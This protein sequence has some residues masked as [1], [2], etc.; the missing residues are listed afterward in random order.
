MLRAMAAAFFCALLG[1]ITAASIFH[2][3]FFGL[4]ARFGFLGGLLSLV[5]WPS[6]GTAVPLSPI[7]PERLLLLAMLSALAG[8]WIDLGFIFPT[9]ENST[10]FWIFAGAISGIWGRGSHLQADCSSR[11]RRD[12]SVVWV[13]S[14]GSGILI[15]GTHARV[16]LPSLLRGQVGLSGLFGE[17]STFLLLSALALMS[18]WITCRLFFSQES[19]HTDKQLELSCRRIIAAGLFYLAGVLWLAKIMAWLPP[20]PQQPLL[21]DMWALHFPLIIIAGVVWTAWST[22]QQAPNLSL[23][24]SSMAVTLVLVAVGLIWQGPLRDL[25]SSISAGSI[26]SLPTARLWL[27]RSI[28]LRP[29]QTR[30][31]SLLGRLL[32]S[33]G[34]R[35]E[36]NP[37]NRQDLLQSAETVLRQGLTVSHFNLLS[38][39]LGHLYLWQ[40]FQ[41]DDP[42][43]R[44]RLALDA[45]EALQSAVNFAPQNEPAWIDGSLVERLLLNNP[46]A[47]DQ[48]LHSANAVTLS[49]PPDANVVEEKWG[50]HYAALAVSAGAEELQHAYADRALMYLRMHLKQNN[51]AIQKTGITK[52]NKKERLQILLER[53]KSLAYASEMH[54]ILGEADETAA[55]KNEGE[56]ISGQLN[57]ER[58]QESE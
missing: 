55:L 41:T 21:V 13:T 12:N 7:S 28:S 2:P 20:S 39:K 57:S 1:G 40:A 43:E 11:G 58:M 30:N 6:N 31:Y 38:A 8:H 22:S 29:G 4:G 14:I 18:T 33:E 51:E 45:R 24:R 56:N 23:V 5:L 47:A 27:E 44:S 53:V 17:A 10:V 50:E 32:A 54:R 37:E 15:A 35:R 42:R 26:K 48:M 49:P 25:R 9:D 34:F 16:D 52:E 19:A 36:L 46:E 3:G